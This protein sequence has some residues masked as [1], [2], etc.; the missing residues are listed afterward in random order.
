LAYEAI[1]SIRECESR[2]ERFDDEPIVIEIFIMLGVP[3]ET[4]SD[5]AETVGFCERV[6]QDFDVIIAPFIYAPLHGTPLFNA[7]FDEN[8]KAKRLAWP[9]L[10]WL[11]TEKKDSRTANRA[12]FNAR[13]MLCS[14]SREAS[15]LGLV[16]L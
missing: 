1:G 14:L 7:F 16:R 12:V 4:E 13:N 10:G 5:L 6:A 3:G 9:V 8:P 2:V 11:G 15:T